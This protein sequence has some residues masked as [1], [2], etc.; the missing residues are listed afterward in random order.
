MTK[1]L[2]ATC[3]SIAMLFG[4]IPKQNKTINE[5]TAPVVATCYGNTPCNACSNC[6]KCKYCSNGGTCGQ[7]AKKEQTYKSKTPEPV[8]TQCKAITKKGTRCKRAA[9]SGGYCWQHG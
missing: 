4:F 8:S 6:S 9:G 3:L 1:L 7:C 5:N 2:T